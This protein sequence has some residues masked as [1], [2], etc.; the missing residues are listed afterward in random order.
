M[1]FDY[2]IVVPA[3]NEE[4][5]L[6]ETLGLL[7][8]AMASQSLTGELIVVDNNSTDR[9]AA[10]A[11]EHGAT[12]V[13]EP[14]N[15]ISRA[16]NAGA[17][18]AQG[19]SLVFVDADTKIAP[20]LLRQALEN[21]ESGQCCGGG[22]VV[23]LDSGMHAGA[24]AVLALWNWLSARL[25][26]AAG[27]FFYCRREDFQQCG[28]FSEQVYASE[29]IWLSRCLKRIGRNSGRRFRVIGKPGALSSGRKLHWY[30][31]GAQLA[32]LFALLLFPFLV[33][34]KRFCAFWYQR[35]GPPP[36]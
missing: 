17:R 36:G 10:I 28:G 35:P 25:G 9:T 32:L 19:R 23:A 20:A 1:S 5:M 22:A 33:R 7:R 13:F 15:Q 6:G 30:G 14:I 31:H 27:C 18:R 2:S 4:A 11:R 21:L 8:A 3:Y 34:Y 12:V 26:L 16:R 24:R 29:E